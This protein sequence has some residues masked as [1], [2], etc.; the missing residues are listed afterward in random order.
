MKV[1]VSIG[2]PIKS[3]DNIGNV[4]LDR[5]SVNAKKLKAETTPE[6]FIDK[7]KGYDEIIIVDALEFE[8]EAGQVK[9]FNLNEVDDRI[10]STH[11]IPIEMFKKFLPNSKIIIIGIKPSNMDFGEELSNELKEKLDN[12]SKRVEDMINAL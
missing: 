1:V 12:I 3:D 9:K 11:S 4:I 8:G 6:N 7:M 2:N 10:L 5:I